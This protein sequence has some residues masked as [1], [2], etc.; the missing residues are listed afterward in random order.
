MHQLLCLFNLSMSC[1]PST[2][3]VPSTLISSSLSLWITVFSS[4]SSCSSVIAT[5]LEGGALV[6]QYNGQNLLVLIWPIAPQ[7]PHF[8]CGH[9]KHQNQSVQENIMCS[10]HSQQDAFKRQ[11]SVMSRSAF[12]ILY[13]Q[14][15][16]FFGLL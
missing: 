1:F 11:G 7:A 16:S 2:I 14:V 13:L 6:W 4:S 8:S 9:Q 15:W 10:F 5:G 3:L 12:L